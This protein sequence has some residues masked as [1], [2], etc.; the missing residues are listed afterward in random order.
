MSGG[1]LRFAEDEEEL[2]G[3]NEPHFLPGERFDGGGIVL[4]AQ[5]LLPHRRVFVAN[6]VER[7]G[8]LRK[9]T[10]RPH[11]LDQSLVT[12]Q[13]I[14]EQHDGR[15]CQQGIQQAAPARG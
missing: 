13:R 10:A 8:F 14:H 6:G 4:Q 1:L 9:L 2:A 3:A 5:D 12:N 7:R 15:K 11:P